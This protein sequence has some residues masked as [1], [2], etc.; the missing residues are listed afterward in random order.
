MLFTEWPLTAAEWP[1][2]VTSVDLIR[3]PSGQHWLTTGWSQLTIPVKTSKIE[4]HS[5]TLH[6]MSTQTSHCWLD[7]L[8]AQFEAKWKYTFSLVKKLIFSWATVWKEDGGLVCVWAVR[9]GACQKTEYLWEIRISGKFHIPKNSTSPSLKNVPALKCS[10]PLQ[11][12][13]HLQRRRA[14][15]VLKKGLKYYLWKLGM[16]F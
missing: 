2:V 11:L 5:S 1:D 12:S 6:L 15:L 10:E 13:V 4:Q 3:S 9:G 14:N 8:L 7:H 16:K